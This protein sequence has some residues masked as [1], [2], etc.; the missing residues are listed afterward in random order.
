[1]LVRL[2]HNEKGWTYIA[3]T[4]RVGI[5]PPGP[6][7]LIRLLD[8][9]KVSCIEIADQLNAEPNARYTRADNE[10]IDF[11]VHSGVC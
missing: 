9:F 3:P 10:D 7:Y 2:R 1:V 8:Q 5:H 11:V 4:A 6:S